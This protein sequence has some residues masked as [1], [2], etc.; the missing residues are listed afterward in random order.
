ME[1]EPFGYLSDAGA[2]ERVGYIDQ[3]LG[4]MYTPQHGGVIGTAAE[5]GYLPQGQ[6]GALPARKIKDGIATDR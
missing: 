2:V 5:A 3:V 1:S 4:L 6:V